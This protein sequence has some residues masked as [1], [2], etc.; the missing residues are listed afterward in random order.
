MKRVRIGDWEFSKAICGTNAFYGRSHFSAARDAEY[1]TRFSP[2]RIARVVQLGIARGINTVEGSASAQLDATLAAVRARSPQP[3]HFIGS[4]R[5]DETSEMKSHQ[6]KLEHLIAVGAK[7]CIVHAQFVDRS[8]NATEIAG[9]ETLLDKIHA[10]GLLAGISTHQ[11]S[12]VELCEQRGYAIDTYMFPLNLLGFVYPGYRG[13]ETV[14]QRIDL[15][16]SVAKPFILMKTLGAGRIPPAEGLQF[17]AE[18]SK[19]NDVI[20]LG[21]GTE[22]E[23]E[24]TVG[25]VEK[26]F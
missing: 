16:R 23:L 25:L 8:S 14:Q 17:V 12:T 15:V 13:C 26:Y 6:Q 18:N 2:E 19:P 4:T 22:E 11:V 21:F 20:S 1:Q 5:I 24:E 7:I 9:L 3:V 10:A